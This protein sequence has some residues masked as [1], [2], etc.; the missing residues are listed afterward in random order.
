MAITRTKTKPKAPAPT[1]EGQYLL[2]RV[3]NVNHAVR[4]KSD[5]TEKNA[6]DT[7]APCGEVHDL[8]INWHW[9][10][11]RQRQSSALTLK[12][13]ALHIVSPLPMNVDAIERLIEKHRLWLIRALARQNQRRSANPPLPPNSDHAQLLGQTI[14]LT[15][16][17]A[18][19]P[20]WQWK[21]PDQLLLFVRQATAEQDSRHL[22]Q[23]AAAE[24]L[25]HHAR[26]RIAE[27]APAMRV[28]PQQMRLTH[29]KTRWGSCNQQ[30]TIAL[31]HQL[32]FLPAE[33]VDY[34][35]IHELAHLREMNHSPRFWN[36]VAQ[37]CPNWKN[38]REQLKAYQ[39]A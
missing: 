25:T 27:L 19:R 26:Q 12:K 23:L 11:R 38:K 30:G 24:R 5:N 2:L 4:D 32:A 6:A 16:L 3:G 10:Q 15:R 37:H 28:C 39:L 36:I 22:W 18:T 7:H 17:P 35:I 1:L 14:Y 31:N 13:D 29:A 8:L 33:L 21:T 9:Q 20:R 34:V